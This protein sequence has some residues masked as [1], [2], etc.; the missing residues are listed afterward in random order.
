MSRVGKYYINNTAVCCAL[1]YTHSEESSGREAHTTS[2]Q[3]QKL[4][5]TSKGREIKD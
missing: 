3:S 1:P 2:E 5:A 4:L